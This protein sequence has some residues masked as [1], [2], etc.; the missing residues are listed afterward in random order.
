MD[1]SLLT[2]FS[3]FADADEAALAAIADKCRVT[4][5]AAGDLVFAQDKVAQG[6]YGVLEGTVELVL[7]FSEKVLS[8]TIEYEEAL[9]VNHEVLE[10]PV[11]VET[12]EA[13]DVFGWSSMVV[14][15]GRWTASARCTA[16]TQ[17]FMVPAADLQALFESDPAVGYHFMSRLGGVIAQR[18][19]HRT[20][21]L[22]D[23]WGEAFGGEVI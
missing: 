2:G 1:K 6:I 16:P 23:A 19:H 11:V 12:L 3:I 9:T 21:K 17:V 18:L 22:V 4:E 10:K 8:H 7:V 15:P 20:A 13:G 5:H 14:P